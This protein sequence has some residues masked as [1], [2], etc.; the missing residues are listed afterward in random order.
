MVMRMIQA[1]ERYLDYFSLFL[2]V[3]ISGK[4]TQSDVTHPNVLGPR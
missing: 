1:L 2:Q 4:L 3:F